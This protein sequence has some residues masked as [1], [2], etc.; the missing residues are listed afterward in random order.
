MAL[1][2][3]GSSGSGWVSGTGSLTPGGILAIA[4]G[5]LVI[6]QLH[7]KYEDAAL[8]SVPTGWTD[9]GT[10]ANAARTRANDNG[11]TRT[12]ILY[13]VWESGDSMPA[14]SPANNNVSMA[15]AMAF[16]SETGLYDVEV[17]VVA[18]DT[19]GSPLN[20]AGS[21]TMGL[22]P[23]SFLQVGA[24]LNGDL[25]TFSSATVG[26]SL[27]GV[28]WTGQPT[29]PAAGATTSG[30]DMR[31]VAMRRQV[32]TGPTGGNATFV[33]TL[34]GTISSA[35][36]TGY[37]MSISERA[38]GPS[39]AGGTASI[40]LSASGGAGGRA[41]GSASISLSASAAAG[42]RGIGGA[43]LALSAAGT[44]GVGVAPTLALHVGDGV[45]LPA[46]TIGVHRGDGTID[47]G[48]VS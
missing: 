40:S 14:L 44:A 48:G 46:T 21:G 39:P 41:A 7:S 30:T 9:G 11:A 1:T 26:G 37:L 23:G 42:A 6:V 31:A 3:V 43:S 10:A 15:T 16:R 12:R 33:D 5:D 35:V 47:S 36:G 27:T 28:T 17:Q 8:P 25:P 19:V 20:I 2:W 24:C 34:G 38:A 45:L 32:S 4:V 13:K 18:D 29:G 22:K